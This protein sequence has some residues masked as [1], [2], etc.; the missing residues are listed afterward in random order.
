MDKVLNESDIIS[1]YLLGKPMEEIVKHSKYKDKSGVYR[2]LKRN[3]ITPDRNP[4]INLSDL[5]VKKMIDM[6]NSSQ[7]V[8][9][10]ELGKEFGGISGDSVLRILREN[11]VEIRPQPRKH[12]IDEEYFSLFT[13]DSMYV[14]AL[15][16][17]D[18][19]IHQDY[20][21]FSIVQK[22]HELLQK[23]AIN[24]GAT[25]EIIYEH[26]NSKIPVLIV[27]SQKMVN[28]LSE[29]FM[30][31]PNK[32]KTLE[33]PQVPKEFRPSLLRGLFDGDGHFSKREAG[34]VTASESFAL[35]FYDILQEYDLDPKLNL[36]KPNET[37]L[38]RVYVRGKD[39]LQMLY[40]ILYSDGCTLYRV[41]KRKKLL[42]AYNKGDIYA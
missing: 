29:T 38:F 17:T 36:E 7:K 24:M 15:I 3:N 1:W 9:A 41:D 11:G 28:S 40:D 42:N 14:L 5:K 8:T 23:I 35:S 16:Q 18:G 33:M 2:A 21:G 22:D 12:P 6:Y 10:V 34:F 30:L 20:L 39:K 25:E 13:P 37:W 32:S 31:H 19:N 27:R 4:R 26:T